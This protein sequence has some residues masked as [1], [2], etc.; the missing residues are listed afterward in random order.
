MVAIDHRNP[1]VLCMLKSRTTQI[2]IPKI[3]MPKI[4]MPKITMPKI[5]MP[6]I[7][8]STVTTTVLAE[9]IMIG[10]ME[11]LVDTHMS[12]VMPTT[13]LLNTTLYD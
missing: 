11:M 12:E 6:K 8:I 9:R 13:F 5:T 4:T 3:T 7:T 10:I 1:A 2:P